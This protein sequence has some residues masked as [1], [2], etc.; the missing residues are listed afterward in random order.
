M[1]Y[2][3]L[4]GENGK[5]EQPKTHVPNGGTWGIRRHPTLRIRAYNWAESYSN[6]INSRTSISISWSG[7][8]G[9]RFAH[10]IASSSDFTWII[11]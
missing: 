9:A 2:F 1:A 3:F 8:A 6:S 4:W 11:Q 10:S 5:A 7:P